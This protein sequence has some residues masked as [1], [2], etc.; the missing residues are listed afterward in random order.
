MSLR[1]VSRSGFVKPNAFDAQCQGALG[2]ALA[3]PSIHYV[4]VGKR[5]YLSVP[6]FL[7]LENGG[8]NGIHL[9]RVAL[10]N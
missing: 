7:H 3:A 9:P 2:Q 6:W 10:K 8:N 1:E 4:T 5:L